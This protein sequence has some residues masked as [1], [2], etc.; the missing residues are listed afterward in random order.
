MTA[1]WTLLQIVVIFFYTNLSSFKHLDE[2]NDENAALLAS[3]I[4]TQSYDTIRVVDNSET[5]PFI[6]RFY[7][8]YVRDEVVAVYCSTFTVFFMQTVLEVFLIDYFERK[9]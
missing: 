7:N 5:G 6:L 9:K 2:N 3:D 8:E 1:A 4:G